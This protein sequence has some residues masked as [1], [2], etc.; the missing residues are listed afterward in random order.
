MRSNL[1]PSQARYRFCDVDLVLA[2]SRS[3]VLRRFERLYAALRQERPEGVVRE[4][5]CL[6]G[7]D[8]SGRGQVVVDGEERPIPGPDPDSAYAFAL[9]M[10]A[11]AGAS[12]TH[13]FVHAASVFVASRTALLVGGSGAG[14]STLARAL[15]AKGAVCLADDVTPVEVSTGIP[16]PLALASVAG[17]DGQASPPALVSDAFLLA[18]P[19]RP[20]RLCLAIDR[21]PREWEAAP[22]WGNAPAAVHP[23]DGY[24]EIELGKAGGGAL[25]ALTR[26]CREA[27][28]LV[29]RDLGHPAPVFAPATVLRALE[30]SVGL[31]LLAAHVMGRGG[32]D[33]AELIWELGGALGR[34]SLWELVPGPPDEA[35]QT[36]LAAVAAASPDGSQPT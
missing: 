13:L 36:V 31:P 3:G 6:I 16:T 15:A 22:P 1:P 27:G 26:A 5:R 4:V 7:T 17:A 24:W 19:A 29:L 9:V 18:P 20:E 32:R 23:R 12:R 11:V 2:A 34:A 25:A 10:D 35:V 14:K 33:A 21:F 28:V 8:A 30:P